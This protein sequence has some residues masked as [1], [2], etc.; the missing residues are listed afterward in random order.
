M[1]VFMLGVNYTDSPARIIVFIPIAF[2]GNCF[3][4]ITWLLVSALPPARPF[5]LNG[6]MFSFIGNLSSIATPL[7][8]GTDRQ[9]PEPLFDRYR[10]F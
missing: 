4:S 8:I 2:F 7:V 3:A 5:G 10:H 6:G 9:R 1:T